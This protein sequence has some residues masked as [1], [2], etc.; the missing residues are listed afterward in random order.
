VGPAL[1]ACLIGAYPPSLSDASLGTYWA[2][3]GLAERGHQVFVVTGAPDGWRCHLDEADRTWLQPEFPASGGY[4]RVFQAPGPPARPGGGTGTGQ[5]AEPGQAGAD[6]QTDGQADRLTRCATAVISQNGCDVATAA[7][8][9]PYSAAG[10]RAARSAGLPLLICPAPDGHPVPAEVFHPDAAPMPAAEIDRLAAAFAG[11]AGSR[12]RLAPALDPGLSCLGS[13]DL[14]GSSHNARLL[15]DALTALG[16]AM[17]ALLMTDPAQHA[18]LRAIVADRGLGGQ[19][20]LLPVLPPWRLAGFI[21]RCLA[22]CGPGPEAAGIAAATLAC[23]TCLIL[24]RRGPAGH[25]GSH[26]HGQPGWQLEDGLSAVVLTGAE[27]PAELAER[28]RPLISRPETAAAIGAGGLLVSRKFPAFAEFADAWEARL[29]AMPGPARQRP[30]QNAGPY[31]DSG[32]DL[33]AETAAAA[34]AARCR[35]TGWLQFGL[36]QAPGQPAVRGVLYAAIRAAVTGLLDTGEAGDFFYMHK[37]PGLRLRFRAAAGTGAE[38]SG[39]LTAL[40]AGWQRSGLIDGWRPG[41]YEPEEHLFGGPVSMRSVHRIFTADSM[42]WLGFHTAGRAAGPAWA[43]SLAQIRALF[44]ALRID[45]WEDRDVWDRLRWQAGRRLSPATAARPEL[46]RLA[47]ALRS[48][49]SARQGPAGQLSPAGAELAA[50]Y[51]AAVLEEGKRWRTGYL[52]SGDASVGAR[53]LAAFLIVFH[54]NRAG[55]P[56]TRQALLAEAMLAIRPGAHR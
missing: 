19:V 35:A 11:P 25:P 33:T 39:R 18:S 17:N 48:A 41:V 43:L 54:W 51:Q 21:R 55:F 27:A 46:A 23:G 32:P 42:A 40:L 16:P 10:Y 12:S 56:V 31:L 22:L 45:G 20:R 30:G 6:G 34:A 52:A 38:L 4:V 47:S 9:E 1:R 7:A 28:L 26:R 50:A 5:A 13:Y 3:R 14:P 36:W 2:A 49:W 44:R 24:A 37:P 8:D 29:R 53:E 15:L